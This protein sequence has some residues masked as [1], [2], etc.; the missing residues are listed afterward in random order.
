MHSSPYIHPAGALLNNLQI[1]PLHPGVPGWFCPDAPVAFPWMATLPLAG[2]C[3]GLI[4]WGVTSNGSCAAELCGIHAKSCQGSCF[5]HAREPAAHNSFLV[6][7]SYC[8][9]ARPP[10]LCS[11]FITVWRWA[12]IGATRSG[13]CLA[14]TATY[15]VKHRIHEVVC[16]SASLRH[17]EDCPI[18]CQA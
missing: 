12:N 2:G 13:F 9:H 8:N 7:Q 6:L 17:L 5:P 16:Y 11:T 15:S 4:S 1:P 10:T 18:P 3:L 14:I